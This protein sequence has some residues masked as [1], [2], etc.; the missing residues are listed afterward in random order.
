MATE[1]A[2]AYVQIIPSAK[3]MK[4]AITQQLG[5][6]A[7]SAGTAAGASFGSN[8]VGKLKTVIAAAGIGKVLSDAINE[9]A[10]L[11]Q[12]IGGIETLFKDSADT[13]KKYADEAG[14]QSAGKV[15]K[16]GY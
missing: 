12:S 15:P 6:E 1:L 9:G 13:V 4:G 14:R 8:L 5:G 3:G 11:Q 7:T 2:S 16:G 10:N